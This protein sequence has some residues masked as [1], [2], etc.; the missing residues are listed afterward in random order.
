MK[1]HIHKMYSLTRHQ[2]CSNIKTTSIKTNKNKDIF[3]KNQI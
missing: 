1:A 3:A 2:E